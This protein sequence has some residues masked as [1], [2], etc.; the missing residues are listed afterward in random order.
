MNKKEY[1]V[2]EIDVLEIISQ[3]TI[4]TTSDRDGPE[5]PDDNL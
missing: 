2:P 5:L 1:T 4:A 3:N